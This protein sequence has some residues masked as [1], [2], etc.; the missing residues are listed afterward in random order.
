MD[1]LELEL[2]EIGKR[3]GENEAITLNIAV[4]EGCENKEKQEEL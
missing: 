4:K 1:N 2:S 3:M